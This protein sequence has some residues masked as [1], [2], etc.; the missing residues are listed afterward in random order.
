MGRI[1]GTPKNFRVVVEPRGLGDFGFMSMGDSYISN[2][3]ERIAKLYRE[4]CAEIVA[5]IKRHADEVGRVDI[6]WDSSHVCGHCGR[7][8]TEESA[9]YNGGCCFQ[10]QDAEDARLAAQEG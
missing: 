10:D 1:V 9:E 4:R 6:E 3:P 8:W 5:S 2:D 7:V